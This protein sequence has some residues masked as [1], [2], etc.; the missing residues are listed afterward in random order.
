MLSESLV[1]LANAVVVIET[2]RVASDTVRIAGRVHAEASGWVPALSALGGAFVGAGLGALGNFLFNRKLEG[3]RNVSQK[4]L[5]IWQRNRE[6]IENT[7]DGLRAMSVAVGKL[8]TTLNS[9]VG[10]LV[11]PKQSLSRKR[12]AW[13]AARSPVERYANEVV[14]SDL[15]MR[16]GF[17]PENVI[18]VQKLVHA[19][20]VV[21]AEGEGFLLAAGEPPPGALLEAV[22]RC[23]ASCGQ[24]GTAIQATTELV[25]SGLR[26][27][28]PRSA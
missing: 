28:A 23:V 16:H 24:A 14:N 6:R 25:E 10:G 2:V 26:E 7:L 22:E 9:L 15:R 13:I 27:F 19:A 8:Q 1:H 11:E 17:S 21:L 3:Q 12:R 4:Q 18:I 20:N 5:F